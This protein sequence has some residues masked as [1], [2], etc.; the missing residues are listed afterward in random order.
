[1]KLNS[2][3]ILVAGIYQCTSFAAAVPIEPERPLAESR[4]VPPPQSY[5]ITFPPRQ[6]KL[7]VYAENPVMGDNLGAYLQDQGIR[8]QLAH[9]LNATLT[10]GVSFINSE[11]QFKEEMALKKEPERIFFA[12]GSNVTYFLLQYLNTLDTPGLVNAVILFDPSIPSD[13]DAIQKIPNYANI[14]NRIYNMYNKASKGFWRKIFPAKQQALPKL[15]DNRYYFAGINICVQV[16]NEKGVITDANFNFQAMDK[17]RFRMLIES[18]VKA[19]QFRLETDLNAI[20]QNNTV[21]TARESSLYSLRKITDKDL[22]IVNIRE[23]MAYEENARTIST[24]IVYYTGSTLAGTKTE[25]QCNIPRYLTSY[26]KSVLQREE[27]LSA[28]VSQIFAT[29]ETKLEDVLQGYAMVKQNPYTPAKLAGKEGEI[30]DQVDTH[31]AIYRMEKEYIEKRKPKVINA[32]Q[33]LCHGEANYINIA[34]V[35]SGGGSRAMFATYG[36]LKALQNLGILDATSYVCGLSGSTWALASLFLEANKLSPNVGTKEALMKASKKSAQR[37]HDFGFVTEAIIKGALRYVERYP[38][39]V[40][41]KSL[42]NEPI[43]NTDYYGCAIAQA[44][45]GKGN[46]I[47]SKDYVPNYLSE[48]LGE[49]ARWRKNYHIPASYDP[50]LPFPIYTAVMP[51]CNTKSELFPWFE[52]TP[53]QIGTVLKIGDHKTGMFVK[54]WSFGR[55]F[56]YGRTADNAP[57]QALDFYL[58]VFGSAMNSSLRE[59]VEMVSPACPSCIQTGAKVAKCIVDWIPGIGYFNPDYRWRFAEV[60]NP[61]YKMQEDE[62]SH[63]SVNQKLPLIDAGIAF[64]LP[65]P[66][67]NDHGGRR[68]ERKPDVIIF[69]DASADAA[70]VNDADIYSTKM[71]Q[72]WPDGRALRAVQDYARDHSIA[73]P[74]L[75]KKGENLAAETYRIFIQQYSKERQEPIVIYIP[76]T[77][78][79]REIKPDATYNGINILKKV[80]EDNTIDDI[81]PINLKEVDLS[82]YPTITTGLSAQRAADLMSLMEYNVL[83]NSER[84]IDMIC[85]RARNEPLRPAPIAPGK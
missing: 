28:Y 78:N 26:F 55:E 1:M 8:A 22:P 27:E 31:I 41:I 81:T 45:L 67:L 72:A 54:T 24:Y 11:E 19:N 34:I 44:L 71:I 66:P 4:I 6:A 9:T 25:Y 82:K 18:I 53:Y 40:K 84:I 2:F 33:K 63:F 20:I 74:Q 3:I 47:Y 69:I 35:A 59:A 64:N 23:K 61:M 70:D 30:V 37:A 85:R 13:K 10:P 17:L 49:Q 16:I 80:I 32:L 51:L 79:I 36:V 38:T 52:F 7:L 46:D 29:K 62:F 68:P 65:F 39:T 48:Q 21:E 5:A 73:F 15:Y 12:A 56:T 83:F 58:G 57:E 77:K 43:T 42:L 14:T 50:Q 60:F 76:V 75:P